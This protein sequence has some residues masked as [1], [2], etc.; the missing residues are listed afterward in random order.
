[1]VASNVQR[2]CRSLVSRQL[3]A[4]SSRRSLF[5][6]AA[7]SDSLSDSLFFSCHLV[8]RRVFAQLL[9]RDDARDA[10]A[11]ERDAAAAERNAELLQALSR[12]E[13]S[14]PR[15]IITA[16]VS[17]SV[18]AA[19][20]AAGNIIVASPA[21]AGDAVATPELLE[22]VRAAFDE[23]ELVEAFTPALLAARGLSDA[24]NDPCPRVLATA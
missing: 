5:S 21:L 24:A 7:S 22:R 2:C 3:A 8:L 4:R 17:D 12:R 20:G 10:A 9:A 16:C 23:D 14:P 15:S 1:M 6:G 18:Y 19:L 11:A 13:L